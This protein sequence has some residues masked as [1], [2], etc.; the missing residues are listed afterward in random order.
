MVRITIFADKKVANTTANTWEFE[1]DL[2][3]IPR[4]GEEI[5]VALDDEGELLYANA[6]VYDVTW[7]PVD[8]DGEPAY[9]DIWARVESYN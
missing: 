4:I 1:S 3:G 8:E 5:S 6:R 9:V 7:H 2:P